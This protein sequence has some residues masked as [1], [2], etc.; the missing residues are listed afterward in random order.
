MDSMSPPNPDKP[1]PKSK[2]NVL[3][4]FLLIVQ[5]FNWLGTNL[6]ERWMIE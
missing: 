2:G 5:E 4:I 6:Q 3:C 1:E